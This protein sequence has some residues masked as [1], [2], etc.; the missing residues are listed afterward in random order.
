MPNNKVTCPICE[1]PYQKVYLAKHK[2]RKP[3]AFE[4]ACLDCELLFNHK[5]NLIRHYEEIHQKGWH[6]LPQ[7]LLDAPR[8]Q[9]QRKA[10]GV[11]GALVT[12]VKQHR[13]KV[14]SNLEGEPVGPR[15]PDTYAAANNQ[16]Y[17]KVG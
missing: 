4:M 9:Y 3:R 8:E 2:C 12:Q 7:E 1:R 5:W 13:C 17:F 11:C 10:C 16:D 6:E 15:V 14:N